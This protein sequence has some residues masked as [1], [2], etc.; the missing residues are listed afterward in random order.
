M[1]DGPKQIISAGT[2]VKPNKD[3][4]NQRDSDE[5]W[6]ILIRQFDW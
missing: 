6:V 2:F 4:E 5:E 1:L 3:I